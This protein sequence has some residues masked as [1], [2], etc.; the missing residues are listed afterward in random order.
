MEQVRAGKSGLRGVNSATEWLRSDIERSE[1]HIA[2]CTKSM[3]KSNLHKAYSTTKNGIKKIAQRK[4]HK[5][6]NT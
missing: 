2:D 3:A 1:F 6:N 4:M 5:V